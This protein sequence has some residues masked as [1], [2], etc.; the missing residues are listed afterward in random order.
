[1]S[2][3]R[4]IHRYSIDEYLTLER[5]SDV[6]HEYLDGEIFAMLGASR[7]HNT[8][9]SN[10]I[11]AIHPHLRGTPC[12]IAS[13]D[14]KALIATAKHAYYPD[15]LVSCNDPAEEI[16]DYTE[17]QPRLIIEVLSP[18]TAAI[19]RREKRLA[20]QQL[21]S[22]QHYVLIT[23]TEPLVEVYN[24]QANGWTYTSYA[25]GE[26]VA[27][28]SLDLLLPMTVIYEGVPLVSSA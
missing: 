24:R 15:L 10:L 20:Y 9:V 4:K 3:V 1:M 17:T 25:A 27:L 22:L 11:A 23:Q 6:R 21:E 12:R 2:Q 16:D 18:S 19:D 7:T 5:E 8:L 14:M 28:S 26:S 13:S